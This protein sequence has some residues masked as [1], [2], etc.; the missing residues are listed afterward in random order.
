M[1]F[2]DYDLD[3]LRAA[4][5][6][7]QG[8]SDIAIVAMLAAVDDVPLEVLLHIVRERAW[9]AGLSCEVKLA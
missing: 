9:A 2:R 8:R 5:A 7:Y 3:E 4:H 6:K 1:K